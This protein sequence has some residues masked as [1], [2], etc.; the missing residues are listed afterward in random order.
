MSFLRINTCFYITDWLADKSWIL[1]QE[2][3][4][5]WV[6]LV[7]WSSCRT[8]LG[9]WLQCTPCVMCIVTCFIG[10]IISLQIRKNPGGVLTKNKIKYN[11]FTFG[12]E[13]DGIICYIKTTW[14]P[15][16]A[17]KY[18]WFPDQSIS[19]NSRRSV[20]RIIEVGQGFQHFIA[21]TCSILIFLKKT[22]LGV[23]SEYPATSLTYVSVPWRM[24]VYNNSCFSH[25]VTHK[26][27]GQV[28][29]N[30][31]HL[32]IQLVFWYFIVGVQLSLIYYDY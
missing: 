8:L 32:Y 3:H 9:R 22:S 14:L 13:M 25:S 10:G 5:H 18:T 2:C 12:S 15:Q 30:L 19:D 4:I 6:G 23:I 31:A 17:Y 21:G 1:A 26:W 16:Q 7:I 11:I 20:N 24:R 29:W 27:S 28:F